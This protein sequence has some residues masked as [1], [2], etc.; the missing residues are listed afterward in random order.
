M[1]RYVFFCSDDTGSPQGLAAA[2]KAARA[3]GVTVVG[4]LAGSM[5]L[6][7]APAQAAQLAKVLPG[8]RYS[9]ERKTARM[10]ER[11]PLER[12]RAAAGK[13]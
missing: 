1:G 12:A 11:R 6:E 4:S 9:V 2:K 3:L 8:W 5:L 7:A 10:P 13:G